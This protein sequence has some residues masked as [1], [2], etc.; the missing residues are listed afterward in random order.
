MMSG[1]FQQL[2]ERTRRWSMAPVAWVALA[3]LTGSCS[4]QDPTEHYRPLRP[5]QGQQS[6][7]FGS[8]STSG[9]GAGISTSASGG[10]SA[11]G[12]KS[13]TGG[14]AGE[15]GSNDTTGAGGTG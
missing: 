9:G 10:A 11:T 8:S 13:S 1:H 3:A 2:H 6:S 4:T 15:S 5:H 7:S 12:D 14:A